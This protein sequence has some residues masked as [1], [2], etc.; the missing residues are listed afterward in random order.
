MGIFGTAL[1]VGMSARENSKQREF[2]ERMSNTAYQ[3][4]MADMKLAGLNPILA[5]QKGGASTP[6]AGGVGFKS[7][8]DIAGTALKAAQTLAGVKQVKQ[9]TK[10]N[11]EE[12][13]L[14]HQQVNTEETIQARNRDQ[15]LAARSTARVN[16]ANAAIYEQ[17][18]HS[19]RQAGKRRKGKFYG[20]TIGY[21]EDVTGAAGN[22]FKGT[23]RLGQ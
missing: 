14:K 18:I 20:P 2:A 5:Y 23:R 9:L 21:L 13:Q 19:A 22:V 8:I 4:A 12:E 11:R 1:Q 15:G 17:D 10:T 7:D 3:R 6:S 16:N